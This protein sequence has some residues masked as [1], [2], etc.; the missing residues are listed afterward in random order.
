MPDPEM[1][2]SNALTMTSLIAPFFVFRQTLSMRGRTRSR[3]ERPEA[4]ILQR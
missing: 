4:D 2:I 3:I 1:I